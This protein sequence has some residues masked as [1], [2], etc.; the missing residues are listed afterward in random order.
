MLPHF[1]L[2]SA[3]LLHI[4]IAGAYNH[5]PRALIESS[6]QLYADDDCQQSLTGYVLDYI[7]PPQNQT[8]PPCQGLEVDGLGSSVMIFPA[9]NCGITLYTD[10]ICEMP[11]FVAAG[12]PFCSL[13]P[14][15]PNGTFYTVLC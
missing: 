1:H 10:M 12:E 7:P 5:T 3:T 8:L 9:E 15:T 4:A 13:A 2:I 6:M 14:S 11:I